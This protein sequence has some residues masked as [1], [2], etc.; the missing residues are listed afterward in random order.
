MTSGPANSEWGRLYWALAAILLIVAAPVTAS[1]V[2]GFRP[3][4]LPQ[5]M[6][7]SHRAHA[8]E[9]ECGACHLHTESLPAAGMPALS[10]CLDCH[11][12]VQSKKPADKREE[13]KLEHYAKSGKEIPWVL[14]PRLTSDIF[15]SHRRHV[16]VSKI[17]CASCHGPIERAD[18]A[19]TERATDFS[20]TWCIRCHEVKEASVDC[21][22]CHR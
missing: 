18:S 7:F 5:P 20:M 14:L 4:P 10:D 21:L 9:A 16:V 3:E 1:I 13:A 2:R 12:G 8:P 11:E 17:K 15:F 22:A 19:P 6:R